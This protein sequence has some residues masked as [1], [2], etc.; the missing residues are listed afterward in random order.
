MKDLWSILYEQWPS[1]I[2]ESKTLSLP[3]CHLQ[4][5]YNPHWFIVSLNI[6]IQERHNTLRSRWYSL[7]WCTCRQLIFMH[8]ISAASLSLT[9]NYVKWYG[10][11]SLH[12]RLS[13]IFSILYINWVLWN[14]HFVWFNK[15]ILMLDRPNPMII[16]WA[17]NPSPMF[18]LRYQNKT[19]MI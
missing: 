17:G 13:S 8:G 7:L 11:I 12:V 14:Y 15:S 3:V 19:K 2:I 10:R 5:L 6:G 9:G 18:N 16:F 1:K 4:V